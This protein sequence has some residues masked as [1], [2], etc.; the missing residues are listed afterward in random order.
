MSAIMSRPG[1]SPGA[2]PVIQPERAI[3]PSWYSFSSSQ[4]ARGWR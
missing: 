2:S 4:S 3:S 1:T